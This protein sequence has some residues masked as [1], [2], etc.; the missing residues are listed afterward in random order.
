[1]FSR[2]YVRGV[3]AVAL[4]TW[5]LLGGAVPE[6]TA[7]SLAPRTADAAAHG[8]V[9]TQGK[10]FLTAD[11]R[12]L[13]LKGINLG[14]WLVPEG[15]MF[16]FEV[17]KSPR[18]IYATLERLVGREG[19]VAFWREFRENFIRQEDI[20]FI[21]AAGFNT[22]RVPLHYAMF[23]GDDSGQAPGEGWALLD[24]LIDWCETAG[25]Y[26]VLD[27]H[28][29]PGGQTGA[30]HDDGSGYPLL[31][32][33]PSLQ[34]QTVAVWRG[35]AE[36]YKDRPTVLGYDLLNEPI[37]SYSDV[38]YLNPKLEPFYRRL[39]A[40]IR[41][42][43]P[44]HVIFPRRLAVELQFRRVRAAVRPQPRLYVSQLLVAAVA[45]SDSPICQ[46]QLSL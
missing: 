28:A 13:L 36:R 3:M 37:S 22:V 41:T 11:G 21:A 12:P 33:L 15:Y 5:M 2:P 29:A 20:N 38:R 35:I 16:G 27:M 32:Y 24:R 30:N 7:G 4:L 40:E 23:A 19:A 26:I 39:V 44:H 25:L 10:R 34:D 14:N 31:F 6:A 18:A 46:L 45:S 1:M 43:D 42:V 9:S 17:A 8:F